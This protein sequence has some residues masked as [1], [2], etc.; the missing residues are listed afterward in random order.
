MGNSQYVNQVE[1]FIVILSEVGQNGLVFMVLLN[2][3]HYRIKVALW[4]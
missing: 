1:E 3:N 4:L 2:C